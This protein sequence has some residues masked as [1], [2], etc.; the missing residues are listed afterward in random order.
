LRAGKFEVERLKALR[1]NKWPRL[2]PLRRLQE[3]KSKGKKVAKPIRPPFAAG[4][5]DDAEGPPGYGRVQTIS[6]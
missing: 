2:C 5:P 1:P 6:R 3:A 4:H